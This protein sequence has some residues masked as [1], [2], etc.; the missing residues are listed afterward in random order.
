VGWTFGVVAS[1]IG[2]AASVHWDL[3]AA[4]SIL[5]ALTALLVAVGVVRSLW[6]RV[7]VAGRVE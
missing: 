7:R 1:L 3:P 5:V 6:G 4:P 2:L